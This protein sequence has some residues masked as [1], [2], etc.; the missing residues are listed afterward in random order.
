MHYKIKG[1]SSIH[2]SCSWKVNI[3]FTHIPFY[4]VMQISFSSLNV[5]LRT[6][7]W[8]NFFFFFGGGVMWL[9]VWWKFRSS[10]IIKQG[11][12]LN[13]WELDNNRIDLR[14]ECYLQYI[15]K[16]TVMLTPGIF[17]W[18]YLCYTKLTTF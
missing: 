18:K 7:Y 10:D 11:G 14:C 3:Q 6:Q 17:R 1:K 4:Q 15:F 12:E 16:V 9:L 5:K 13:L 2:F 8:I